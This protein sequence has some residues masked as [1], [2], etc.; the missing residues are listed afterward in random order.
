MRRRDLL[1]A[2]AVLS[3]AG[4]AKAGDKKKPGGA[5]YL[6]IPPLTAGIIRPN[7]QRGVLTVELGIDTPD[8]ALREQVMELIPRLRDAYNA[9]TQ[10]FGANL[11]PGEAPDLDRLEASLQA[12]TDRV[13]GRRGARILLGTTLVN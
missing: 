5:G 13:V 3:V 10:I 8:P 2:L 6:T 7:G 11:R 9:S 4:A 12:D 1:S